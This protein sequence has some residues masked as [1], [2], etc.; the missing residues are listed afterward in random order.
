MIAEDSE[1]RSMNS[2]FKTCY[3]GVG[4]F[5]NLRNRNLFKIRQL[6]QNQALEWLVLYKIN[7]LHYARSIVDMKF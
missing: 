2:K 4:L 7:Q 3:S 6:L 1:L 5:C